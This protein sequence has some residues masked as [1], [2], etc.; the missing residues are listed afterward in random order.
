MTAFYVFTKSVVF[1]N[2]IIL[3]SACDKG[4]I[5]KEALLKIIQ[6]SPELKEALRELL[7]KD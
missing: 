6:E 2:T 5:D 7:N 1:L 4:T 3:K